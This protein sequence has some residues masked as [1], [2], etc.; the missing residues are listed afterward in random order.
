MNATHS[1]NAECFHPARQVELSIVSTLLCVFF[2]FATLVFLFKIA[3]NKKKAL[4]RDVTL[5][6]LTFVIVITVIYAFFMLIYDFVTLYGQALNPAIP[7]TYISSVLIWITT[8]TLSCTTIM[9]SL[10][11]YSI[12]PKILAAVYIIQLTGILNIAVQNI[13]HG[14]ATFQLVF[15]CLMF[16]MALLSIFIGFLPIMPSDADTAT[17]TNVRQER[18]SPP[19]VE[20]IDSKNEDIIQED[21]DDDGINEERMLIARELQSYAMTLPKE[22]SKDK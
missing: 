2:F 17:A 10:I 7:C 6:R 15:P 3:A 18:P 16:I 1:Q 14:F 5:L 19:P 21:D 4:R 13:L 8:N 20:I 9:F 12:T 22:H 11:Q